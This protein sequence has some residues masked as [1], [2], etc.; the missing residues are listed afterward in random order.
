M[1]AQW[2]ELQLDR[3]SSRVNWRLVSVGAATVIFTLLWIA[4]PH[5]LLYWITSLLLAV[6][7]W[8]ASYGWREALAR[9]H[10]LVHHLLEWEGGKE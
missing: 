5:G 6:L 1:D 10:N 2:R 4:V 9:I 3:R 7:V 8:L